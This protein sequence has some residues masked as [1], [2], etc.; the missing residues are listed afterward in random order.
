MLPPVKYLIIFEI[1]MIIIRLY[2]NFYYNR[3]LVKLT[4]GNSVLV[5]SIGN[6]LGSPYFVLTAFLY[7]IQ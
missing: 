2:H 7:L 1:S 6:I 3:F 4:D 5:I